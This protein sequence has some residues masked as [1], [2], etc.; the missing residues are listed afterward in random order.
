MS[1]LKQ[2]ADVFDRE[3]NR[4]QG[5]REAAKELARIGGLENFAKEIEQRI[6]A[7]ENEQ[8]AEGI[9]QRIAVLERQ[10]GEILD[11][12]AALQ[13][14]EADGKARKEVPSAGRS[15]GEVRTRR[16][17]AGGDPGQNSI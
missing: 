11:C 1:A 16:R 3:A 15:A 9:R 12:I 4:L 5:L 17:A 6:A 13:R 8:G 10:A 2:A 14:E 7:L